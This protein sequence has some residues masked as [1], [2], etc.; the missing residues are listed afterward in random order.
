MTPASSRSPVH[1]SEDFLGVPVL[2][3]IPAM[4]SAREREQRRRRRQLLAWWSAAAI[5]V[6]VLALAF[7]LLR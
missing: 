4:R 6:I 1:A 3:S 2:A 7:V 5:L